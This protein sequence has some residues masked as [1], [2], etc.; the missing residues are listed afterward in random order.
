MIDLELIDA[1]IDD[2][3]NNAPTTFKTCEYLAHL[4]ITRELILDRQGRKKTNIE[5]GMRYGHDYRRTQKI[6][7]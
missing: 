7:C 1:T 2:L 3:I 5:G 4:T 6:I